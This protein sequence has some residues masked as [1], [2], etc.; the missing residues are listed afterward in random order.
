MRFV[1]ARPKRDL[2]NITPLI[3]VVFILLVFFMVAGAIERPDVLPVDLPRSASDAAGEEED[4]V[5]LVARD[6]SIA[7]QGQR[8]DDDAAFVRA[9][10]IWFA[11]RPDSSIQL[12]ADGEAEAARVIEVMELLR[13]AGAQFLMLVTV[14]GGAAP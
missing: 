3:D 10:A 8:I 2:I 13:E 14:G 7:F 11:V 12:K 5:I 4:V 6:G 9:A 1:A